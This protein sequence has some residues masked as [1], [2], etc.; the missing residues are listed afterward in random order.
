[1]IWWEYRVLWQEWS[2]LSFKI[3]SQ[4]NWKRE[5]SAKYDGT[6]KTFALVDSDCKIYLS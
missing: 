2:I 6:N 1:M 5:K 4:R 3:F